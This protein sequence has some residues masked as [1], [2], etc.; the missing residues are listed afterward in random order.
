MGKE[1]IYCK[2]VVGG[3]ITDIYQFET[4]EDYERVSDSMPDGEKLI[5][6]KRDEFMRHVDE[7]NRENASLDSQDDTSGG[8]MNI[9]FVMDG[10]DSEA[11]IDHL[12]LKIVALNFFKAKTSVNLNEIKQVYEWLKAD[13]WAKI[14]LI[15]T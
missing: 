7:I 9:E 1:N 4:W 3:K 11:P 15:L 8:G 14:Y 2:V 10:G 13:D 6:I 12:S 5:P